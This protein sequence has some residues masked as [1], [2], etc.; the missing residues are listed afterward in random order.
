MLYKNWYT[1]TTKFVYK[2]S[3]GEMM[4]VSSVQMVI[5]LVFIFLFA[6]L[7]CAEDW[8]SYEQSKTGTMYYEKNSIKELDKNIISVW[9]INVYN[10]EGKKRDFAIL[11]KKNKAPSDPDMLNCTSMLVELDCANKKFKVTAWTIYDKEKHVIYS[12][13]QSIDK[14][15][16]IVARSVSEKLKNSVCKSVKTSQ[17][18]KK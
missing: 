9:T 12:A 7:A 13:P 15:Q 3:G 4:K 1:E 14:W 8:I 5:G 2:F 6:N 11:K 16:N 17:T 10:N 18:K